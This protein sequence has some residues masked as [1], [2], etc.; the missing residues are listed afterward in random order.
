M[1]TETDTRTKWDTMARY[2][3]HSVRYL[4]LRAAVRVCVALLPLMGTYAYALTS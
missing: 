1:H 4:R 2:T 3:G